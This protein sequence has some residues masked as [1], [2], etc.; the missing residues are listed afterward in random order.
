M[1]E[2][3]SPRSDGNPLPVGR[4]V[5]VNDA[6]FANA[7]LDHPGLTVA[8]FTA[9]WCGSPWTV[10]SPVLDDIAATEHDYLRVAV[11]DI[12]ESPAT[13]RQYMVRAVPALCGRVGCPSGVI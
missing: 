5:P 12:D 11:L 6:S 2:P 8:V 10:L 13:A 7:V 9:A 3:D 1:D 4:V